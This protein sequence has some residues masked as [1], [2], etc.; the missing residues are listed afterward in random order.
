[1]I[2]ID[3]FEKGEIKTVEYNTYLVDQLDE[4]KKNN[5]PQGQ[6][7]SLL[8]CLCNEKINFSRFC[9][10]GIHPY[11]KLKMFLSIKHFGSNDE[12]IAAAG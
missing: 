6:C 7:T 8:G 12:V 5:F 2:L 3:I 11:Q 9:S 1:M 4:K 10:A